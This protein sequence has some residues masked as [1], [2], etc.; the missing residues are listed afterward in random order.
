MCDFFPGE[1]NM[2]ICLPQI[3][4]IPD[5]RQENMILSPVEY[6]PKMECTGEVKQQI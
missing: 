2:G 6:E 4:V 3:W 5:L 1:I